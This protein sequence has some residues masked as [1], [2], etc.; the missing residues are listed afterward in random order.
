MLFFLFGHISRGDDPGLAMLN[1][2]DYQKKTATVCL[3]VREITPFTATHNEGSVIVIEERFFN[4]LGR[5]GMPPD[6]INRILI[7][8]NLFYFHRPIR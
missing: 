1:G 6:V 4:L 7:P 8:G 5:Y 2:Q 3:A